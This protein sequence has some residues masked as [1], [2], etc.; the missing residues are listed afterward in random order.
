MEANLFAILRGANGCH[1]EVD[2]HDDPVTADAAM[3][4]T[5][6]QRTMTDANCSDLSRG[7]FVTVTLPRDVLA[8]A[9]A[10]ASRPGSNA[11]PRGRQMNRPQ[12]GACS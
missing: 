11:S 5:T 6:V 7:R 9:V 3:S 1:H 8:C 12:N 4:A 10:A 2:F